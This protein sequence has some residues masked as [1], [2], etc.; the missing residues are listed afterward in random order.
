MPFIIKSTDCPAGVY[1]AQ[2]KGVEEMSHPEYG[3]GLRFDFEIADEPNK[4]RRACRITSHDPTPRNAAG[5]MLC[6]LA[7]I[8]PANGVSVD[9]A[10]FVGRAY[11]IVVR[12]S[13]SG[14]TRVES[15][16]PLKEDATPF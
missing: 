10:D 16:C 13:E 8:T 12:E 9:P 5:R 2:F 4:G 11:T 6:D 1:K 7:G 14:R 15:V 3:P